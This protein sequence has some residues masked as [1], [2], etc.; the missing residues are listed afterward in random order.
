[1]PLPQ[2]A[3]IPLGNPPS[4]HLLS[5]G[6]HHGSENIIESPEEDVWMHMVTSASPDSLFLTC[7]ISAL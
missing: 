1:M 7:S 5:S 6:F 3:F 4:I 2:S